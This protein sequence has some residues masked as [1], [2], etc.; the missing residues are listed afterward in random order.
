MYGYNWSFTG[1]KQ[2]NSSSDSEFLLGGK[3]CNALYINI[4]DAILVK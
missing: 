4:C 1:I 2:H 3:L